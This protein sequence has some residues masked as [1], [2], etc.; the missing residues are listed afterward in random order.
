M[1]SRFLNFNIYLALVPVF[2]ASGCAS[3]SAKHKFSKGEQSTIRLYLES[4]RGDTVSSAP[5]LVTR[6]RIPMFIDRE[7]SLTEADLRKADVRDD[8]GPDGGYSIELVFN[9]HGAMLLEMLTIAN[10]GRHIVVFSQFPPKGYKPPKTPKKPH[11]SD[12]GD[13]DK[14]DLHMEDQAP[15]P[16]AEPPAPGQPRMS[17][18]LAAV[19]IRDRNPT[20]TFRFSPDCVSRQEAARIVRGLKNDIAYAKK[21]GRD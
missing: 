1:T 8:P 16:V 5:V 2:L 20:G 11:K 14:D 21:I 4:T 9:E 6:Q 17:G 7:P 13:A 3:S 10:K 18:W 15:L 19:L 12:D